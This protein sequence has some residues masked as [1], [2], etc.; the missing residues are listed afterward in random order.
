MDL[1]GHLYEGVD[2]VQLRRWPLL[3]DASD[4][5]L[6][7]L[8]W[9]RQLP[10][11]FAS[12]YAPLLP[13]ASSSKTKLLAAETLLWAH[14]DVNLGPLPC[15]GVNK[16]SADVPTMPFSQ[17]D[18]SFGCQPMRIVFGCLARVWDVSRVW[19]ALFRIHLHRSS[20]G[21]RPAVLRAGSL[22]SPVLVPLSSPPF[23]DTQ[24]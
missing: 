17:V 1:H 12:C 9:R 18:G 7:A 20:A 8:I 24:R 2:E 22:R 15:Q 11:G 4:L 19:D 10:D 21:L 6:R 5:R 3:L 14:E 16:D 13:A 23:P